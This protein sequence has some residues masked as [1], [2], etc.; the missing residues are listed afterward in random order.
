MVEGRA[1]GQMVRRVVARQPAVSALLAMLTGALAMAFVHNRLKLPTGVNHN[2]AKRR[3]RQ[4][5]T[6]QS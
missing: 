2:S 1:S 5:R 4:L 3:L 6:K